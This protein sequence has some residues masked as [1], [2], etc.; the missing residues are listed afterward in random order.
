MQFPKITLKTIQFSKTY[1]TLQKPKAKVV[2]NH[3]IGDYFWLLKCFC[4]DMESK[5]I[6]FPHK[7]HSPFPKCGHSP[8]SS[9]PIGSPQDIA[10]HPKKPQNFKRILELGICR[11]HRKSICVWMGHQKATN[12]HNLTN[13]SK[14]IF[15][16]FDCNIV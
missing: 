11:A 2:E 1:K 5:K 15:G 7:T 12:W 4:N 10:F 14:F 13:V 6:S 8:H 16:K 9:V 3:R